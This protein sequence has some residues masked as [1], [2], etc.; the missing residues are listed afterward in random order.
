MNLRNIPGSLG[1]RGQHQ[2][3]NDQPEA[4]LVTSAVVNMKRG[5]WRG[6]GEKHS[7][8]HNLK[9]FK[10]EVQ[11]PLG[12]LELDEGLLSGNL[13]SEDLKNHTRQGGNMELRKLT[14]F[15]EELNCI[16]IPEKYEL[17]AQVLFGTWECGD[18]PID[19]PRISG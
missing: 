1:G 9:Y 15:W 12:T 4:K 13:K 11:G 2:E 17:L 16:L 6:P 5:E 10:V 3:G 18:Q 7:N 19:Y 14:N 8:L